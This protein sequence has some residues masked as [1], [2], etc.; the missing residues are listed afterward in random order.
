MLEVISKEIDA[1]NKMLSRV[2]TLPSIYSD[3]PKAALDV[4][5]PLPIEQEQEH[6]QGLVEEEVKR[7]KLPPGVDPELLKID[8]NRVHEAKD[9]RA[10]RRERR[11]KAREAKQKADA[12]AATTP[13][14]V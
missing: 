11:R 5:P 14:D 10:K 3:V 6:W 9:E 7:P 4:D 1:M 13:P 12:P 2:Q 8:I